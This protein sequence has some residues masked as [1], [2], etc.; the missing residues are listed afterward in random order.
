MM[1][2]GCLVQATTGV[3]EVGSF[4]GL[5]GSNGLL[6]VPHPV[7]PLDK[8]QVTPHGLYNERDWDVRIVHRSWQLLPSVVIVM[9]HLYLACL[10]CTTQ[11]KLHE[12]DDVE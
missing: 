6:V 12:K 5:W 8:H 3:S 4:L 7:D 2:E 10:I 1:P 9:P 11:K